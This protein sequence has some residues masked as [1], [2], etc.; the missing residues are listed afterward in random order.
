MKESNKIAYLDWGSLGRSHKAV[1]KAQADWIKLRNHIGPAGGLMRKAIDGGLALMPE[2]KKDYPGLIN[3]FG[4]ENLREK[5][6]Q[7]LGC[8]RDE[9]VFTRNTT[10]AIRTVL[11]SI[12]LTREDEILTSDLEHDSTI[13][14]CAWACSQWKTRIEQ[15]TLSDLVGTGD[16]ASEAARRVAKAIN[17]RTR[18]AILSHIAYGNGA[19]L[20]V[21]AT[22]QACRARNPSTLILV[23]GAHS[24]GLVPLSMND[25]RCDFFASSGTKWLLA[26]EG[27]GILYVRKR[28]SQEADR[29]FPVWPSTAYEISDAGYALFEKQLGMIGSAFLLN[30]CG[31]PR[32][33]ELGTANLTSLVGLDAALSE[34]IRIGPPAIAEQVARLAELAKTLLRS[35]DGVELMFISN[36]AVAPGIVCFRIAQ[37]NSY[38]D[39]CDV[40]DILDQEYGV[41]CRAIPKPPC[42]RL[43][44][45]Y[46]NTQTDVKQMARAV[47]EVAL[48]WT[49]NRLAR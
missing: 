25:L 19:M 1:V 18:I 12:E 47:K 46:H 21:S 2:L 35:I 30:A 37:L 5:V 24:L 40:I 33:L 20:P 48:R 29:Q 8:G 43:S 34:Y 32:S 41:I 14:N 23:D 3:W 26:P 27:T 31:E 36:H 17:K 10:D 16:F 39:L 38:R 4:I 11:S 45:H 42:V 22:A 6:A 49:A 9:V 13:Y 28:L 15:V 7:V 44:I